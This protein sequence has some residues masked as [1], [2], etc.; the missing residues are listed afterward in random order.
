[1]AER[2]SRERDAPAPSC[3]LPW[4][5]LVHGCVEALRRPAPAE[6]LAGRAACLCGRTIERF[7]CGHSRHRPEEEASTMEPPSCAICL[8][9]GGMPPATERGDDDDSD[10]SPSPVYS[11]A[12]APGE[13]KPLVLLPPP[14]SRF[15]RAPAMARQGQDQASSSIVAV[16]IGPC[17]GGAGSSGSTAIGDFGSGFRGGGEI[18]VIA[19][20]VIEIIS[21]FS[22]DDWVLI[23]FL[24]IKY[25]V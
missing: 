7:G 22:T 9:S 20:A 5:S 1:M 25:I 24:K 18:V 6:V 15:V 3:C 10:K 17:R 14:P 19:A 11:S 4:R 8:P 12:D 16:Q 21:V 2:R 13:G 23:V